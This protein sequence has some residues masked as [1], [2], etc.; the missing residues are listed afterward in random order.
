MQINRLLP[1]S[2]K[3]ELLIR[4]YEGLRGIQLERENPLFW[5]QYA[6]ARMN[7]PQAGDLEQA[8]KYL[9]TALSLARGRNGFTTV[10]I[11]TQEARLYIEYAIHTANTADESYDFFI[12]ADKRLS[13]ITKKEIYKSEPYRPMQSYLLWF[14]KFGKHFNEVQS[15]TIYDSLNIIMENIKRLPARIG[16]EKVILKTRQVLEDIMRKLEHRIDA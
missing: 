2:G 14:N 1:E 16:E 15:R 13:K 9:Q 11:E 4:F 3:R 8:A 7:E 6:M 5:L 10:D 12:E